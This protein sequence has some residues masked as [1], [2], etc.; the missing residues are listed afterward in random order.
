MCDCVTG[1]DG[2]P[3]GHGPFNNS[4]SAADDALGPQNILPPPFVGPSSSDPNTY[5]AQKEHYMGQLCAA[6]YPGE[7]TSGNWTGWQVMFKSGNMDISEGICPQTGLPPGT[8]SDVTAPR[9]N[10]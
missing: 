5:A 9:F 10:K 8:K 2:R 3:A 7:S 1:A 4:C 6:P